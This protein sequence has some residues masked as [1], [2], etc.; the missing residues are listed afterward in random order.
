MQRSG[1]KKKYI[2][3]FKD[4]EEKQ[5]AE[6]AAQVEAMEEKLKVGEEEHKKGSKQFHCESCSQ[7][8]YF[9]PIQILKHKKN[10]VEEH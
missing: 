7:I 5:R 9:T 6:E 4:C 10:C 3:F 1:F 2:L 8:F